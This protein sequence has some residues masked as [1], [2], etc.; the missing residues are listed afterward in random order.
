MNKNIGAIYSLTSCV[1]YITAFCR[2]SG[3]SSKSPII[4]TAIGDGAASDVLALVCEMHGIDYENI[5]QLKPKTS[6]RGSTRRTRPEHFLLP[7]CHGRGGSIYRM[8]RWGNRCRS[9][10]SRIEELVSIAKRGGVPVVAIH[11]K[12]ASLH[13]TTIR[14]S[15]STCLCRKPTT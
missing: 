15:P 6:P 4:A 5:L 11:M 1:S 9:G 12:V 8:R 3:T 7:W 2:K 13:Q 14:G 10:V